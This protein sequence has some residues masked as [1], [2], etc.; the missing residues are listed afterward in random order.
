MSSHENDREPALRASQLFLQFNPAHSWQANIENQT[1][2]V[3]AI[4]TSEEFFRRGKCSYGKARRLH[5]ACE[6]FAKGFVIID[7]G[8]NTGLG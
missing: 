3:V 5:D 2:C 4:V 6:R 1:G 8:D 7:D